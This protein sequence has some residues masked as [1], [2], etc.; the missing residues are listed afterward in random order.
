MEIFESEWNLKSPSALGL[1]Y[2][3]GFCRSYDKIVYGDFTLQNVNFMLGENFR[4]LFTRART[5]RLVLQGRAFD[6]ELRQ[7][8][9]LLF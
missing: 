5:Q 8:F 6:W 7:G 9:V 2:V 3:F 4:R 1:F